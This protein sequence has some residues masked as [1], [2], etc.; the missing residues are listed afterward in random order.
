M[1]PVKAIMAAAALLAAGCF[2]IEHARI[3]ATGE[4]HVFASN[5]GWYLFGSLPIVCG[6]A[7][8]DAVLPFVFFR[9]DVTMDK[10]QRRV[11]SHSKNLN[12]GKVCNL[13]YYNDNMVLFEFPGVNFPVP[14][15]YVLTYRGIQLSGG[16]K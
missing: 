15:P 8:P 10:I 4:Y 13:S 12:S 11:L 9:D 16:V 1:N 2:S 5:Y 14:V 7:N 3:Q 6:N